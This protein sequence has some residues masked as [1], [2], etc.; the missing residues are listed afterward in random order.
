[1]SGISDSIR[2]DFPALAQEINGQP[3]LY[4]DNAA[5]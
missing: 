3:L 4:F 1:M 5:T 2:N